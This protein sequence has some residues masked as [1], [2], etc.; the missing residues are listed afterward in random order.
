[1]WRSIASNAITFLI[2]ALFLAGGI[3]LWGRGQYE[4]P[5]PLAQA[6]CVQVERGTNF[7]R[8]SRALEQQAAA[9]P[10]TESVGAGPEGFRFDFAAPAL[11]A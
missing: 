7:R 6:I 4:A 8:V 9:T 3:I 1:M 2:V 11:E 10:S 5:G